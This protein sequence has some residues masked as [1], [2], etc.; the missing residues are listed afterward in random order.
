MDVAA[1]VSEYL[2]TRHWRINANANRGQS[3]GGLILNT[4]GK[5]IANYWM[6]HVV[7]KDRRDYA[8]VRQRLP[9]LTVRAAQSNVTICF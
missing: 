8:S 4:P 2:D 5:V 1:S 3:L 6:S 9:G 7:R